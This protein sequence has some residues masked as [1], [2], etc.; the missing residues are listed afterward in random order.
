VTEEADLYMKL[1][2]Y[3]P[4]DLLVSV[5]GLFVYGCDASP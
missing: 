3:Y 2:L 4:G 1:V 5:K